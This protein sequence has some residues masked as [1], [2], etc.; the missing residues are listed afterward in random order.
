MSIT[1]HQRPGVYSSYDASA[2]V[3]GKGTGRL[4]GLAAVN[5]AAQAGKVQTVTS[6]DQAVTLFGAGGAEDMSEL[7]RLALK[8]GASGVAAVAVA[9]AE[10]YQEAFALLSRLENIGVVLCDSTDQAVQKQLRDSVIEASDQRRE[11]LCVAAGAKGESVSELIARAKELNH[12]R[13]V[14]AAP[15]ALDREGKPI[16]GLTLAAAVAGAIA[17]ES[18]PAV[19]LG[20]AELSGLNGLSAQLEDNDIDLLVL[21]GVTPLESVGGAVSVIR[22]VTTRTASGGTEDTAWRDLSSIRVV[23]D[24]IPGLRGALR[25]RFRQSK[26]TEQS[27][28]A[29]RAQVVLELENKLAREIIT[30]YDGVTVT[31]DSEDPTRCLVDFSFAVAH[32]LNQIWLTAHVTV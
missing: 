20:G 27:R 10:G 15:G 21:G 12:E 6:Y 29:I 7:I 30:G 24:V 8:N 1:V 18:D 3:S 32:G 4:V 17:G 5:T 22:G 31:A 16:S 28:G 2:V 11:R 14:L 26:N 25:A 19:P 9:G 13:V 23:D